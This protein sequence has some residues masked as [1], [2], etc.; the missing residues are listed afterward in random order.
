[1]I[2]YDTLALFRLD[3]IRVRLKGFKTVLFCIFQV[4]EVFPCEEFPS[5]FDTFAAIT[6]HFVAVH[7]TR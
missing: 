3:L 2:Q 4:L 1:M 5:V 7:V 6:A